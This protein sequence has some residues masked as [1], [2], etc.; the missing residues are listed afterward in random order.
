[1]EF[2]YCSIT[3]ATGAISN[4]SPFSTCAKLEDIRIL[5]WI[6]GRWT[7]HQNPALS[8]DSIVYM[9]VNA[10]ENTTANDKILHLHS[11]PYALCV[12][13]TTQYTYNGNTYNGILELADAKGIRVVEGYNNADWIGYT[14]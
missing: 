6:C 5:G 1:M 13:D 10:A 12:N 9:I 14:R 3:S 8:L 11:T 4:R 2:P 7:W